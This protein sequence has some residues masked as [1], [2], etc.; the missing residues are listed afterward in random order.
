MRRAH[1]QVATEKTPRAVRH[2]S[3][4]GFSEM[5]R[6]STMHEGRVGADHRGKRG[7]SWEEAGRGKCP[8]G[9]ME[10]REDEGQ[11]GCDTTS[12]R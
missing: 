12:Y 11:L 4:L 3:P 9:C 7:I 5:G 8:Y 1:S 2:K 6:S 10:V